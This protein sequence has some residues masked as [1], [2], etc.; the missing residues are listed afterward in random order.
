MEESL[1]QLTIH[2]YYAGE[3][4]A[5]FRACEKL[6][7]MDGLPPAREHSVRSNRTWY[8]RRLDAH[9]PCVYGQIKVEPPHPGWTL[10]NP[11]L[12]ATTE[13]WLV[14]V[15][16]SNYR[17]RD[18][19][20]VI[21]PQD[22]EYI[23]TEN[24]LIAYNPDFSVLRVMPL[25]PEYEKTSFYS[26]GLE[27]IRLGVLPDGRLRVSATLRNMAP[28][29]GTCR[30]G[31]GF[32]ATDGS[33]EALQV[34]PSVS[35]VHEKNWMPIM[36][37]DEWLYACWRDGR[38]ATVKEQN[39]HWQITDRAPSCPLA[40]GFR[41]GSQVVAVPGH[42]G[43]WLAVI[44]E[45]AVQSNHRVY[46]H[47]FVLFD[48]AQDFRIVKVSP[49]FVFLQP[50]GIE[51]AA[52]LAIRDGRAVVSFGVHDEDA[53]VAGVDLGALMAWLVDV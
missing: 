9:I 31:T 20:Y 5:G 44:H 12:V 22:G 2:A 49:A 27:D 21:P 42:E 13:G 51:F 17:I 43:K 53:W 8:T 16:S 32:V 50:M 15:R 39:G 25:R 38:V 4:E 40:R 14:N 26:N 34:L 24:A 30:I 45:V 46:E 47:R 1:Y 23:H 33:L 7:G 48:E 3:P 35:G 29:D 52:G 18:W 6:L 28:H 11:S 37:R 36:G 19:R 10:F 41:G